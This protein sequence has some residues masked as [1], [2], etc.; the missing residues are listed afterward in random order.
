M[1][2]VRVSGKWMACPQTRF[3]MQP[4][5][6]YSQT[7]TGVARVTIQ[8]AV[9]GNRLFNMLADSNLVMKNLIVEDFKLVCT[10][11][12]VLLSPL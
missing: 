4:Y 8:A 9:A 5:F 2:L 6:P 7:C 3:V 11:F 12:S 10:T 1:L